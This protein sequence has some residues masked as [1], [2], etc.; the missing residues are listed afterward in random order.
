MHILGRW[1]RRIGIR[2]RGAI[3]GHGVR[4]LD[5][6]NVDAC[7]KGLK[8]GHDELLIRW[9][10]GRRQELCELG[11]AESGQHTCEVRIVGKVKVEGLI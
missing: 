3:G 5:Y 7:S 1:T 6:L 10:S 2:W 4:G 9:R 8:M 11:E